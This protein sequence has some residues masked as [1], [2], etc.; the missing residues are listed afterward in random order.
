MRFE[1]AK[2][3]A[4][5]IARVDILYPIRGRLLVWA[6]RMLMRAGL[7]AAGAGVALAER[8]D[9]LLDWPLRKRAHRRGRRVAWHEWAGATVEEAAALKR[10]L[11]GS[12]PAPR[13]MPGEAFAGV[14]E[15]EPRR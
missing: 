11:H 12:P 15:R 9:L 6:A 13:V 1:R 5:F 14:R 7:Q 10:K 3:N 4:R 2:I 8:Y